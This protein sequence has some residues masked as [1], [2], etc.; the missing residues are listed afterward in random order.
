MLHHFFANPPKLSFL[1][2]F[3]RKAKEAADDDSGN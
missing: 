1:E 2:N 3:I